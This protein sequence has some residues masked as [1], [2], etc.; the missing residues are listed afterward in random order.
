M[1]A[2]FLI[3]LTASLCPGQAADEGKPAAT[4]VMRAEYPK[5]H[6]DLNDFAPRLFR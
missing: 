6:A 5:V 4:N 3:I 1:R 2:L